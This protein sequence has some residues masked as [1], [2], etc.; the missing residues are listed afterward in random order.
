MRDREPDRQPA[1]GREEPSARQLHQGDPSV[2]GLEHPRL[3][4]MLAFLAFFFWPGTTGQQAYKNVRTLLSRLRHVLPDIDLFMNV[5]AKLETEVGRSFASAR[6][7]LI[8]AMEVSH[9]TAVNN[10]E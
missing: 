6:K 8:G 5:T 4:H 9:V 10:A 1:N 3:Q 2:A 7:A